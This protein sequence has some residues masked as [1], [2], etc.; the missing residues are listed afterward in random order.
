MLRREDEEL[1][2]A[3]QPS[4]AHVRSLIQR[5]TA[6]GLRVE[7]R[8]DGE[9]AA[10]PAGVDLTAYR[11][12]QEALRRA[13]EGGHAA[14]ASVRVTYARRRDPHRGGRRRRA[15]GPR[16]LLGLRER[17]AV[18]GGELKAAAAEDGGWRVA[19]RLPVGATA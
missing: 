15:R 12:V 7:L 1:A 11:L 13:R 16:A 3:P 4:L 17:V 6:A 8:I 5:A 14:R 19:A 10:L 2:L 9:P 18:Y